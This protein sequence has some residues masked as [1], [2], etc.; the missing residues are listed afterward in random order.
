[1]EE[2]QSQGTLPSS[3]ENCGTTFKQNDHYCASCGQKRLPEHLKVS[4][5]FNQFLGNYFD[6][7]SKLYRTII[8]LLF[9]PGLLSL[10]FIEGKRIRYIAPVQLYI[11]ISFI[12]F[13]IAH[14][15]NVPAKE[16]SWIKINKNNSVIT[17][18]SMASQ[19][20]TL[21]QILQADTTGSSLK[22]TFVSNILEFSKLD[23]EARSQKIDLWISYMLFLLL[24]FIA[25]ISKLLFARSK[26]HYF[27]NL[28]FILHVFSFVFLIAI[29][30]LLVWRW[31]LPDFNPHLDLWITPVYLMIA[32]MRFFKVKW[33]AALPRILVFITVSAFSVGVG[34]VLSIMLSIF[35]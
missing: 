16:D 25:L 15:L 33:T 35:V 23:K 5:F 8:P 28:I 14:L 24:P 26:R 22:K 31:I 1:M 3:C 27:E 32:S 34:I 30:N 21:E 6:I 29:A 9:K 20:D 2:S 18:D 10:H 12:Y 4:Y 11:F 17:L 7:D 19:R 13:F